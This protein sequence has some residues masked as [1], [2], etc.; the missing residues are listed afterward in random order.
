MEREI[1]SLK[2]LVASLRIEIRDLK[3]VVLHA[4][5]GK[6]GGI[7]NGVP[8][9]GVP[10]SSSFSNRDAPNVDEK[11]HSGERNDNLDASDGTEGKRHWGNANGVTAR[12]RLSNSDAPNVDV[13]MYWGERK[14]HPALDWSEQTVIPTDKSMMS[15]TLNRMPIPAGR[16]PSSFKN[17]VKIRSENK[18]IIPGMSQNIPPIHPPSSGSRAIKKS[19]KRSIPQSQGENAIPAASDNALGATKSMASSPTDNL[20][21]QMQRVQ[22]GETFDTLMQITMEKMK[23]GDSCSKNSGSSFS[24]PKPTTRPRL[25]A[26]SRQDSARH[27]R[28]S[29]FGKTEVVKSLDEPPPSTAAVDLPPL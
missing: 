21:S 10:A 4:G 5:E 20:A 1:R 9:K 14:E 16:P 11:M 22:Q 29:I 26:V 3:E 7:S 12:K 27:I 8:P 23:F 13:E 19:T 17:S 2:A 15:S 25:G 6:Y 28:R 24:W 18:R